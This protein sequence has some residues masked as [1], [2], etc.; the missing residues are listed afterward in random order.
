MGEHDG[1]TR[2]VDGGGVEHHR[3]ATS[4][5]WRATRRPV[6]RAPDG[7]QWDLVEVAHRRTLAGPAGALRSLANLR[8]PPLPLAAR[9]NLG[10]GAGT[11]PDPLGCGRRGGLGDQRG[12]FDRPRPP[13]CQRRPSSAEPV[14]HTRGIQ[15]PADEG[16]GRR[17]GSLT[18][19]FRLACD[20][21]RR[22]LSMVIT[23]GQR[24]DST[25]LDSAHA[26]IHVPR[27]SGREDRERAPCGSSLIRATAARAVVASCASGSRTPHPLAPAT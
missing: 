3:A 20:G 19:K 8:R 6:A 7:D 18:T 9:R 4:H 11:C 22:P 14:R 5:Q 13:A 1:W 27:P 10:S 21:K 12:Q 25:Q 2:R 15:R 17:R 26:G 23:P 24:R 16:L